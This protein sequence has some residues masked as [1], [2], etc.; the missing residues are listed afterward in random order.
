MCVFVDKTE[1]SYKDKI[2]DKLLTYTDIALKLAEN[3]SNIR[4][5]ISFFVKDTETFTIHLKIEKEN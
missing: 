2:T 4:V 1:R 3:T 5:G